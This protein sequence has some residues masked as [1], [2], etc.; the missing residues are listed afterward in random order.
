MK[1]RAIAFA[2]FLAF[3]AAVPAQ[4]GTGTPP[5]QESQSVGDTI[6]AAIGSIGAPAMLGM[7]AIVGALVATSSSQSATNTTTSTNTTT[8]TSTGTQ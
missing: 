7:L 3:S 4:Q 8:T 5:P 6:Q 2:T 1:L